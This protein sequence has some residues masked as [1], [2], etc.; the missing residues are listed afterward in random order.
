MTAKA[1][2][3]H[4][5]P[6]RE[7]AAEAWL[8]IDGVHP[9]LVSLEKRETTIGRLPTSD[10][11]ISGDGVS[12]THARIV[13]E[14]HHYVLRDCG[15]TCGTYVNGR[16]VVECV[17]SPGDRIGLGRVS[18]AQLTFHCNDVE[19][20]PVT[21]S[22]SDGI[23][24]TQ[25][26]AVLDIIKAIGSG[27][28][29]DEVL[30]LVIDAAL[31]TSAAERGFIMLLDGDGELAVRTARKG[32][33]VDLRGTP[34]TTSRKIPHE[35]CRTGQTAVVLDLNSTS[36]GEPHEQSLR[37][38]I[39]HVVC[40]PLRV[41]PPANTGSGRARII[42]VLYLD[43]SA[44]RGVVPQGTVSA[45]ETLAT[46]AALA[47]ESARLYDE[48]AQKALIE[49]DLR[50]AAEI[51]RALLPPGTCNGEF[52]EIAATA[53]PCRTVGGDFY[54]YLSLDDDRL[55][56]TLG[57][58]AGKGPSA[59]LLAVAVLNTFAALAPVC[60]NPAEL[61]SRT[62]AA[63]LRRAV[64]A[65]FATMFYGVTAPDGVLRYCNAGQE[66]P[67]V[68]RRDRIEWLETG[69]IVLGLF[70]T[71]TYDAGTVRLEPGD[72]VVVFSDGITEARNTAGEEFGRDRLQAVLRRCYGES[73]QATLAVLLREIELFSAGTLQY[74]DITVLVLRYEPP[75]VTSR[76]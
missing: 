33:G 47:I 56:F 43:G 75:V 73:A 1:M 45:L 22:G 39:R 9:E 5:S 53:E 67:A 30:T 20:S 74:D 36:L 34:F 10:V 68:V 52:F 12:R 60:G 71:A 18:G 40:V 14:G 76:G 28:L 41:V 66:P 35:V 27:R 23:D 50:L 69:G 25:M 6:R 4:S 54:D 19:S 46:Q 49:R 58:V 26:A 24:F 7:P 70:G 42:G 44:A 8:T 55:G 51:Q 13:Q 65:R 29:L 59:A 64:E 32:G 31:A 38:G 72:L 2:Q 61:L 48:A 62:N 11:F 3:F 16:R 15:S 37:A 57:D 21:R 17:L 63:L